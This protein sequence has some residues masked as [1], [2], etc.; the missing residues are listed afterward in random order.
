MNNLDIFKESSSS[1]SFSVD[2]TQLPLDKSEIE[3]RN[4]WFRN[5]GLLW[6]LIGSVQFALTL[7][8]N[9]PLDGYFWI[10]VGALCVAIYFLTVT[11]FT[12]ISTEKG[13]I[14]IIKDG[15]HDSIINELFDR[16]KK[17]LISRY[18]DID[19]SNDPDN[20]ISKFHWLKNQ[21]VISH[22]EFEL[23]SEKIRTAHDMPTLKLEKTMLN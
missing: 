3:D 22:S 19:F 5:A 15:K 18:G 13:R 4:V 6:L 10:I 20:E 14:F 1:V 2:Y 11:K 7:S 23:I 16:R 21:E 9:K 12:V 8:T 17:K